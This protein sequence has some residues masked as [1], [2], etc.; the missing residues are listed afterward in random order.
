MDG[1]RPIVDYAKAHPDDPEVH[2]SD[3]VSTEIKH[4]YTGYFS[5]VALY[6]I[7]TSCSFTDL[8]KDGDGMISREELLEAA[9]E[10]L[11]K[12]GFDDQEGVSSL[13]INNVFNVAMS[14]QVSP[15]NSPL[16]S[17]RTPRSRTPMSP[18]TISTPPKECIRSEDI[19]A[20]ALTVHDDIT[21]DGHKVD[22]EL[23]FKEVNAVAKKILGKAYDS[24]MVHDIFD[25]LDTDSKGVLLHSDLVGRLF[26]QVEA[27][28]VVI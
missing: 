1:I 22:R 13:W 11:S 23:D 7:L 2:V 15:V 12:H 4:I 28:A 10:Q 6:N 20:L 8:D 17:P 14:P 27:N 25:E 21:Y 16:N 24:R 3:E 26:N 5:K 9:Q 19:L 18:A